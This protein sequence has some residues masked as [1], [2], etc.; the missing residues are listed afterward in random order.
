MSLHILNHALALHYLNRLRDQST[1][2]ERFREAGRRLTLLLG[3]EATRSL[4]T[5]RTVVSTPL[6]DHASAEPERAF[7][8]VAILRA[9]LGMVEP[10]TGLLPEATVGFTGMERNEENA[11]ALR[12]YAKLPPLAGRNVF[13]VDPMLATGGS[14]EQTLQMVIG[15]E[16]ADVRFLCF[17]AAPEG[18]ER[19]LRSFPGLAIFTA[20]LDRE[21]DQRKYIL[22]GLGDYGDRY[23][24]T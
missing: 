10:L 11:V 17:V 18:V 23:F 5:R 15:Q 1:D 4:A 12:Y 20:A 7:T 6:E 21:L 22:P 13:V 8:I 3:A 24:G 9:G 2:G 19:L 14:A 16:P